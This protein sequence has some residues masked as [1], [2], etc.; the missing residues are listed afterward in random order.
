MSYSGLIKAREVKYTSV[1]VDCHLRVE[2]FAAL[3]VLED[4][5]TTTD[6]VEI[7]VRA[8]GCALSVIYE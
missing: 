4:S 8:L 1:Q 7:L 2:T 3:V 5:F 6:L